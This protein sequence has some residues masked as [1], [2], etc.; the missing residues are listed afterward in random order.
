MPFARNMSDRPAISAP[1]SVRLSADERARQERDA[2]G[3]ALGVY[4]RWRL[5]DPAS[6]PPRQRGKVP[7]KDH[8]ALARVLAL[9]GQSRIASNLNQ[10][11]KA[12]HSGSLPLEDELTR[13]L[14]EA[15][16]H[17]AAIRKMLVEALG[18]DGGISAGT[19]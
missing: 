9:L 1:F 15:V 7:V 18:L 8:E 19:Q 6:P 2:A 14:S 4:I 17:V 13:D 5:L 10:L 11:A 3:M 16:G 12:V